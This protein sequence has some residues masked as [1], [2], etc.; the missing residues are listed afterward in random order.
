[1]TIALAAFG[2]P[3]DRRFQRFVQISLAIHVG[4]VLLYLFFPQPSRPAPLLMTISLGAGAG[5]RT[6]GMTPIAGREVEKAEPPSKRP[7]PVKPTPPEKP[8]VM[9]V[10]EKTVPVKEAKPVDTKAPPAD[11]LPTRPPT[12]GAEVK[13][14]SARVETGATG[15]SAG[16]TVGGSSGAALEIPADFCCMPYANDMIRKIED[17]WK[18][19]NPGPIGN[20]TITFTILRDGTVTGI[21]VHQSS[22]SRLLDLIALSAI[23][24]IKL[25]RLPAAYTNQSLTIR[26]TFPFK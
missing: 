24:T 10:P 21:D 3:P 15:Q 1:M 8:N 7:T 25:D 13:P 22:G 12:T 17:Q 9:K 2:A 23:R 18:N 6:G 5:E 11:P 26:L 19:R 14:G 20:S 4:A 16:N